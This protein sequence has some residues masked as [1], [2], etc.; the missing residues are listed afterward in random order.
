[1]REILI[2]SITVSNNMVRVVPTVCPGKDQ[3]DILRDQDSIPCCVLN[4]NTCKYLEKVGF[5]ID[6]HKETLFCNLPE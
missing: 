1:M 4:S 5:N 2:Q 6:Q 3:E